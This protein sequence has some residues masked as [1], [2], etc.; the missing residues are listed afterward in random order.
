MIKQDDHMYG[1]WRKAGLIRQL[2]NN[3]RSLGFTATAGHCMISTNLM[4]G[5]DNCLLCKVIH[6]CKGSNGFVSIT[7]NS[8]RYPLL[9]GFECTEGHG[10]I[11]TI[12]C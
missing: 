9:R 11:C 12:V 1:G 4:I 3:S 6:Y 8:A 2:G 7:W 5:M 10:D